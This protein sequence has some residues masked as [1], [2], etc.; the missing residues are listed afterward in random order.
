MT[1]WAH[2]DS[3]ALGAEDPRPLKN[4]T[5]TIQN[6]F[7]YKYCTEKWPFQSTITH[8]AKPNT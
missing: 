8:E 7:H 2:C 4:K 6:E 3:G 1:T 5:T